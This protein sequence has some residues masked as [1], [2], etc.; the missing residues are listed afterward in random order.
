MPQKLIAT[1]SAQKMRYLISKNI[2]HWKYLHNYMEISLQIISYETNYTS[3]IATA[4]K[5]LK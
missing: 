1:L 2:V 3:N 4:T 5:H